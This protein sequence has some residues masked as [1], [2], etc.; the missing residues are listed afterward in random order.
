MPTPV[1]HTR[2]WTRSEYDQLVEGGFFQPGE[3]LE[4]V[5]GTILQM[6]P[7]GSRHATAIRLVEESLRLA[8]G[9][10]F[11]VR[12]QLPLA[13]S[14]DSEPEPDVTVVVGNPRDFC[15]AHPQTAVLIVEVSDTTVHYDQTQKSQIYAQAGIP[16]YWILNLPERHLEVYRLPL[17]NS[18]QERDVLTQRET[19]AAV[20]QTRTT[21]IAI[22]D[23]LP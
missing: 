21:S 22:V 11:D 8:Y 1:L 16:E 19:V 2:R 17:G 15:D 3:R 10:G 4:L 12:I 7:Q 6:T 9:K 5:N 23:L 14:P 18:Y 13:L 20:A